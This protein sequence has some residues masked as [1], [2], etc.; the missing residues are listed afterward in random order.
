[1]STYTAGLAVTCNPSLCYV[2]CHICVTNRSWISPE[3]LEGLQD[4]HDGILLMKVRRIRLRRLAVAVGGRTIAV[5]AAQGTKWRRRR[6][7]SRRVSSSANLKG[8][9]VVV[10]LPVQ[11]LPTCGC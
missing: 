1:M 11:P 3:G 2:T 9:A 8:Q 5:T 6:G 4:G 10:G 7:V